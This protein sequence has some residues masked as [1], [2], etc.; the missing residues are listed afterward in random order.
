MKEIY[1]K[2]NKYDFIFIY[3]VKNREL[4]NDCLIAQ[5]LE[6][7]GYKVGFVETWDGIFWAKSKLSTKVAIGF[8]MY[9]DSVLKYIDSFVTDCD[10]Y[11]NMQCEQLFTNSDAML[12]PKDGENFV[13]ITGK[14]C[15]AAHIAWGEKTKERLCN[16][17]GIEPDHVCTA[18]NVALDFLRP[19][20][21]GY[22]LSKEQIIKKY[23]LKNNKI[24]ILFISSFSYVD[25]PSAVSSKEMYNAGRYDIQEFEQYSAASQKAI[26][27]WFD[28]LLENCDEYQVIYRPHP[29]EVGNKLLAEMQK[30]HKDFKV[31][32]EMSIKQWIIISDY[33]YSW[34]STSVT[35]VYAAKK[36]CGILRPFPMAYD[37]ELELYN[38]AKYI[39]HYDDFLSSLNRKQKFP[40]CEEQMEK[41]IRVDKKRP[42]YI[43]VADFLERVYKEDEY[44]IELAHEA[45]TKFLERVRKN[46]YAYIYYTL[47]KHKALHSLLKKILKKNNIDD[48]YQEYLYNSKMRKNNH[49]KKTEILRIKQKIRTVLEMPD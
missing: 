18:G 38:G 22:Y 28:V 20:L 42:A 4:E 2:E 49:M 35:E 48:L 33:I 1:F 23:G 34:Y 46:I 41:F 10:K 14:A 8:A 3:E 45:P 25:M 24:I 16:Q 40:I 47:L 37:R 15:K 13:G 36:G 5:E 9:N 19:E 43:I 27:E 21:K 17:Y 12:T 31:I 39:T 6:K 7:R 32:G 29:A 26:L 30:R 11:V 44:K